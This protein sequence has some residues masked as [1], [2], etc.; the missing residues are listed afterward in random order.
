MLIKCLACNVSFGMASVCCTSVSDMHMASLKHALQ[1]AYY[2][3]PVS[4]SIT[5]GAEAI[6]QQILRSFLLLVFE[7]TCKH[8]P[9]AGHAMPCI[10]FMHS[11][12]NI[13]I[14]AFIRQSCYASKCEP[15][16]CLVL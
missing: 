1:R 16:V 7:G 8:R 15:N 6:C 3:L 14:H 4:C 9:D 5:S 11:V 2:A 13:F 10:S 12:I